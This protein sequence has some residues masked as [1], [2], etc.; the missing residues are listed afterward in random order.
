MP[1]TASVYQAPRKC[2][3]SVVSESCVGDEWI[4]HQVRPRMRNAPT[5]TS[6]WITPVTPPTPTA[7]WFAVAS[8]NAAPDPAATPSERVLADAVAL[9]AG[10]MPRSRLE[11]EAQMSARACPARMPPSS[12]DSEPPNP[13][14]DHGDRRWAAGDTVSALKLEPPE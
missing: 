9:T 14:N 6:R 12:S 3:A 13:K 11:S 10:R 1:P 2:V 7:T 5:P 4:C 8:I